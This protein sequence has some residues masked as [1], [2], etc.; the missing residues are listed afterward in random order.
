[1]GPHSVLL[2]T[3][4]ISV[5][6]DLVIGGESEVTGFGQVFTSVPLPTTPMLPGGGSM[7]F[8]AARRTRRRECAQD[9]HR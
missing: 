5:Y 1:L 3:K 8:A 4:D 9:A 2:V 6:N 7:A